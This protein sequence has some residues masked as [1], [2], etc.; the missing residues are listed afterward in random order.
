M[1][2]GAGGLGYCEDVEGYFMPVESILRY[3][4]GRGLA[5]SKKGWTIRETNLV[6]PVGA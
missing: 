2:R 3:G 1:F 4:G 6:H 5:F